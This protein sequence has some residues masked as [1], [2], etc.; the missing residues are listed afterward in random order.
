MDNNTLRQ[1]Q[2]E[3]SHEAV[4][5]EL[6]IMNDEAVYRAYFLPACRSLRRHYLRGSFSY[7]RALRGM[8]Y[9]VNSAAKQYRLEH[10]SMTDAWFR[11]FP[12]GDR[13]RVCASLVD[14]F[15]DEIRANPEAWK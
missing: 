1:R 5:L 9:C 10:G 15:L 2:E 11:M 14:S 13:D 4:E 8:A 6:F 7:E 12:K 3:Y